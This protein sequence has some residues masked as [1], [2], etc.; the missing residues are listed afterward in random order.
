MVANSQTQFIFL[1]LISKE[2]KH[3]LIAFNTISSLMNIASNT[4]LL[5]AIKKLNLDTNASYR[6]IIALAV[7]DLYTGIIAQP[8]YSLVYADISAD[9]SHA[10]IMQIIA[11]FSG[12]VPCQFSALMIF[13]ISLDRYLHMKHLNLYNLHM[14]K[15]KGNFLIICSWIFATLLALV[16]T[17][18]SLYGFYSYVHLGTIIINGVAFLLGINNY[19]NA[20]LSLKKR[21]AAMTESNDTLQ[22]IHRADLKFAKGVLLIIV[23]LSFRYV[24]MLVLGVLISLTIDSINKK[25]HAV[26]ACTFFWSL[27]LVFLGAFINVV[28]FFG[29]NSKL[30][31]FISS[32]FPCKRLME[33]D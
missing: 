19:I 29:F 20:Y 11:K 14:T 2:Q 33:E 27:Q 6:F 25:S 26:L 17:F 16:L 22:N 4:F 15:R 21:V 13:L 3:A 5:Y 23:S 7:S 18:G 31:H 28:L 10:K 24:P 30:R 12:Y 1:D 32:K 8:L 9:K